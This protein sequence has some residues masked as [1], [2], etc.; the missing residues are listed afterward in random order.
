[1][2]SKP[3]LNTKQFVKQAHFEK[4]TG[5]IEKIENIQIIQEMLGIWQ[6]NF[7]DPCHWNLI[8]FPL[9]DHF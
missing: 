5:K 1:M 7:C 4:Q 9:F 8:N 6:Q 3:H 2:K